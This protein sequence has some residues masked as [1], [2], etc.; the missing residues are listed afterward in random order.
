MS[1]DF[2]CVYVDD[3]IGELRRINKGCYYLGH[4]A[5]A[6]FYADDMA[7]LAPSIRGLSFLLDACSQYCDEWDICL[8]AKKSRVLFFGKSAPICHE[9]KLGNKSVPWA[10][11]WTYLGIQLKSGKQFG[12]TVTERVRK[13]YRCANSILR[14]EGRSND[15]VMLRLL[16]SHCVPVLTYGIEVV[17]V[18]DR[19]ERRA[20]RVAYNSI[21]RKIF[22]Y[23]YSES[24]TALQGFLERP[25]WEELTERR[26]NGFFGRVR[27]G[28]QN[29]LAGRLLCP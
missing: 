19:D 4:F 5:A 7:I 29:T 15:M 20:L 8:N 28:C 18:S 13:F 23:R 17:E 25:T 14:I 22:G 2:Y 26:R 1:P 10:K 9:I 16:E 24:V 27:T 3:L 12:C 21:F 6:L 11:E